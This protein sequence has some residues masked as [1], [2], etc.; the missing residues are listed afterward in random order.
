MLFIRELRLLQFN[1]L[2]AKRCKSKRKIYL[3][4]V[5]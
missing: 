1:A 3:D 2:N 4:T 5:R